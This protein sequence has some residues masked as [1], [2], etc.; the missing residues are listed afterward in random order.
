MTADK[1]QLAK[2]LSA[3]SGARD[4]QYADQ[5]GSDEMAVDS[6]KDAVETAEQNLA[7]ARL[8]SPIN[9]M[10]T[11][12]N[13]TPGASAQA[14]ASTTGTSSGD[15]TAA[16]DVENPSTFDVDTTAS[17]RQ[18]SELKVGDQVTITPTGATTPSTGTVVSISTIATISS[19]VAS[20]PVVIGVTGK[21]T[22]MSEDGATADL[23]VATFDVKNV[24]VATSAVQTAGTRSFVELLSH[25]K[26][27]RHQVVVGAVGGVLTQI[28]AGLTPGEKVVIADLSASLPGSDPLKGGSHKGTHRS[29]SLDP[30]ANQ[31]S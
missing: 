19:G 24:L 1:T 7:D 14:G 12:V 6:A 27:V 13:V 11:A 4:G 29:S 25:G 22:D 20:F 16:I 5:V 23:T 10:V 21:P 30:A 9:G 2:D 3:L 31:A 15:S 26:E 18:V 8:V 28:K 17:S